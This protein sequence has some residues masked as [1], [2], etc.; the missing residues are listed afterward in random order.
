MTNTP[1]NLALWDKVRR[2]PPEHLK[3][4]NNGKFSGTAI[5]PIWAIKAM[6]ETFGPMGTNWGVIGRDFEYQTLGENIIVFCNVVVW[7]GNKECVVEGFGG[8][9]VFRNGKGD[10]DALKKAYTDAL[11]NALKH[12]GV[13]ADI[14]M[15]LWD[16]SKYKD[17]KPEPANEQHDRA[18]HIQPAP[19]MPSVQGTP[20]ASK[21]ANRSTYDKLVMAIRNAPTTKALQDWHKA[22]L[23]EIDALPPDWVD[24]LR[25]EYND[26]KHE[27][28]KVLA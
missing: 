13:A 6:T 7:Y 21:A 9:W 12:I 18:P 2:V 23:S 4:F 14:H 22:N 27:L 24:E 11:G 26:R 19:P 3:A 17:E 15:N 20:G 10:D 25:V 5:K 1:D 16:G 28:N 8:D